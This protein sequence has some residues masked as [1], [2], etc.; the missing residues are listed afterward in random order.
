M[1]SSLAICYGL[2]EPAQGREM[3]DRLWK[4]IESVGFK[5]FDLEAKLDLPEFNGIE[6]IHASYQMVIRFNAD[7]KYPDF[8][9]AQLPQLEYYA[10]SGLDP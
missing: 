7:Q 1:I 4:K 8:K 5:R 6:S 9:S 2:I 3:M 10:N